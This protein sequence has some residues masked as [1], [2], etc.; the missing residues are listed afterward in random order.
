MNITFSFHLEN[1]INI[2]AHA[3]RG[4]LQFIQKRFLDVSPRL[5]GSYLALMHSK[6]QGLIHL[7]SSPIHSN[8][9]YLKIKFRR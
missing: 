2:V 8:R 9:F 1:Q 5:S 7:G 4:P 3:M 6:E